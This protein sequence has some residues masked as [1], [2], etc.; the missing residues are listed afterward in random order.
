MPLC[1]HAAFCK[2]LDWK[3]TIKGF[4]CSSTREM[5]CWLV[6]GDPMFF[7]EDAV[8]EPWQHPWGILGWWRSSSPVFLCL[9]CVEDL[10]VDVTGEKPR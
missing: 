5:R 9:S 8:S 4:P 7:S 6:A 2:L 3:D 10:G 1:L